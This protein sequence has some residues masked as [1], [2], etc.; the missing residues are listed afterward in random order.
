MHY[1]HIGKTGG[2]AVK[3]ALS[4]HTATPRHAIYL[5]SHG[6]TLSD[7]PVGDGVFFFLRDPASR[8]VSGFY[9][10]QRQ[11]QPRIFSPW[12]AAE[13][14]AFE[15]FDSP[16]A[17][18]LALS[19]DEVAQRDAA[20]Q[21]MRSIRH[22]RS[23]YVDWLGDEAYLR[24]RAADILLVGRQERLAEDFARL[25]DLLHLGDEVQ[26]PADDVN[27]HRNPESVD[28]KLDTSAQENLRHW[29]RRDYRLI[30]LCAELFGNA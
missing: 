6:V 24:A 25:R 23:F 14:V 12:D 28:R 9:S 5:H 10:R 20:E 29:Y 21:A 15:H 11:G 16:N 1:L 17:L 27:S 30:E 4:G 26:L 18:A 13:K 2:S 3:Y 19:S 7:V 22:V 8:F